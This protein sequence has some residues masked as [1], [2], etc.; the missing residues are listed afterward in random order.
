MISVDLFLV[1][2]VVMITIAI[3]HYARYMLSI[4]DQ[5]DRAVEDCSAR[6]EMHPH[7]IDRSE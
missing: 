3:E 2:V 1:S 5:T 4:S 6:A 7:D